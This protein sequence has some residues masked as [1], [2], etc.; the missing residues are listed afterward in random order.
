MCLH[1]REVGWGERT[2]TG[3]LGD[4]GSG[5]SSQEHFLIWDKNLT[6]LQLHFFIHKMETI[7]AM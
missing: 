3:M 5:P 1:G 4:Q 7:T 2:V 6:F